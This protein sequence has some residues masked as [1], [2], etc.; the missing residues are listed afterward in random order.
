MGEAKVKE[1]C[2]ET[3]C[4]YLSMTALWPKGLLVVG[5]Q[6]SLSSVDSISN[7]L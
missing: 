7:Q 5:K 2:P 1:K 4:S 6:F 3:P